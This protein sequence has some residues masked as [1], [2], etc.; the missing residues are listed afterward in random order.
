MIFSRRKSG[1]E[2]SGGG[3]LVSSPS[4]G[5]GA[6][7][8]EWRRYSRIWSRVN[9]TGGGLLRRDDFEEDDVGGGGDGVVGSGSLSSRSTFMKHFDIWGKGEFKMLNFYT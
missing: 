9:P 5:S 7:R 1:G 4:P 2:A 8:C 6:R 3:G